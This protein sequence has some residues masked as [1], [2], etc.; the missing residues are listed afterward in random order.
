MISKRL[1]TAVRREQLEIRLEGQSRMKLKTAPFLGRAGQQ[2]MKFE[3][4]RRA[5]FET[6]LKTSGAR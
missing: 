1:K 3:F 4:P 2:S 5:W 6:E